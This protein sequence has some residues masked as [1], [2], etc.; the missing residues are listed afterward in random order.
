MKYLR[1]YLSL[2]EPVKMGMQGNQANS[3]ALSYI[4]GSSIRGAVIN[5]LSKVVSNDVLKDHIKNTRFY[6]AYI[7][8][9]DKCLIPVPFIFYAGKHDI[10]N[11][12]REL[13]ENRKTALKV[14]TRTID[15]PAEGEQRVDVGGFC[16]IIDDKL[17]VQKVRKIAN[18]HISIG[19]DTSSNKLFRYEAIDKGQVF[20]GI[21]ACS[22]DS[23]DEV[24]KILKEKILYLGG[25]KGSGY[26]RCR[27]IKTENISY[28]KIIDQYGIKRRKDSDVL[29]IYALSN[30][31]LFDE[32]GC[33]CGEPS[34]EWIKEKLN[35]KN[36]ELIKSYVQT[37]VASGYNHKWRAGN[38]MQDAVKA[39]SV[40]VYRIEGEINQDI[41]ENIEKEQIGLR[42]Q[43]GFGRIIINP[44]FDINERIMLQHESLQEPV[45]EFSDE[46]SS[47]LCL[48][49]KSVNQ[50]RINNYI[51][52]VALK[53]AEDNRKSIV[54]DFSIT[55]ISRLYG[56]TSDIIMNDY[57]D[58]EIKQ[59][60]KIFYDSIFL[61][62]NMRG[63]T[64]YKTSITKQK[65][66]TAKLKLPNDESLTMEKVLDEIINDEK[67]HNNWGV[68]VKNVKLFKFDGQFNDVR[69]STTLIKVRFLNE[70]M[71]N[72]MRMEGG[73]KI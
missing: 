71:Y 72:L 20:S 12:D 52:N 19:K 3:N 8:A 9:E 63:E 23:I 26:G 38:V 55:Q 54:R 29:Y 59:K 64:V 67:G 56:V 22:N 53:T 45:K 11:N 37:S 51:S 34:K 40:Y 46:D 17:C 41:I 33:A 2:D 57:S 10:R 70:V 15:P 66:N 27:V 4:A 16:N 49:E 35:L 50:D 30:L 5:E 73:K 42:K 47:L 18:M 25:S 24:E 62:T 1:Y 14:N 13:S 6:D 7:V 32:N 31:L 28:E 48:V 36:A 65:Y 60:L 68:K 43:D 58:E 69:I 39:G 61:R 44:D 21:I